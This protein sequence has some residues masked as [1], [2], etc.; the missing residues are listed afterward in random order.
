[1]EELKC[2]NCNHVFKVD[3]E[4]FASNRRPGAPNI[5]FDE[6]I[7]RRMSELKTQLSL[8]MNLRAK[9]AEQNHRKE[10][11]DKILATRATRRSHSTAQRKIT[12][13]TNAKAME[14]SEAVAKRDAE[15][16]RL[17]EQIG[18]MARIGEMELSSRLAEK[19]KAIEEIEVDNSAQR[20]RCCRWLCLRSDRKQPRQSRPRNRN[21]R[22]EKP[23]DGR[24]QRGRHTRKFIK[25]QH[26]LQLKQKQELID[27]YKR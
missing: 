13:A 21:S 2:P 8:E 26:A 16:A 24:T 5:A 23:V 20:L 17:K 14:M 3:E 15:I 1:M 7:Q 18:S 11:N 22:L 9:E 27:Y 4:Q 10:L 12:T 6:E 19:D 25:E